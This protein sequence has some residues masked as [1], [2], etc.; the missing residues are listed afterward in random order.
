MYMN[1]LNL[2]HLIWQ[3]HVQAGDGV[4][5]ATCGNGHDSA[6]LATLNPGKLICMDIQK[7]AIEATKLQVPHAEFILGCHSKLPK[8]PNLKLVTYNLGYLPGGDKSLTTKLKTSRKSIHEALDS[9]LA[10]GMVSITFYP[11]HNEGLIELNAL[12]PELM[13][14]DPKSFKISH[15][16]WPTRPFSPELLIILKLI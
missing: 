10:R 7:E 12:L 9:L 13:Q 1:H 16:R 11:G 4:I 3:A 8:C 6:F 15:H 2:A 14:L 5:D